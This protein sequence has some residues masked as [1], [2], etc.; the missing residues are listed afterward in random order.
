MS[1]SIFEEWRSTKKGVDSDCG[2]LAVGDCNPPSQHS[3]SRSQP[4][5]AAMG[6]VATLKGSLESRTGQM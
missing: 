2:I 5:G 4:H 6:I 1:H 3:V